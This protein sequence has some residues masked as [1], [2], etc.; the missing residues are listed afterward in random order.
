MGS[1]D[2]NYY[3]YSVCVQH[4]YL[5]TLVFFSQITP[6]WADIWLLAEHFDVTEAVVLQSSAKIVGH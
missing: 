1:V 3:Y 5:F 2:D 6:R 4:S